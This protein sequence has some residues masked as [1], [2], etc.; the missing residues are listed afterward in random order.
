L[1]THS[2][3]GLGDLSR[4]L[5]MALCNRRGGQS[6]VRMIHIALP[7]RQHGVNDVVVILGQMFVEGVE[8]P[9]VPPAPRAGTGGKGN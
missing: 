4:V 3:R 7:H 1:I 2:R 6:R 5:A 9:R 8:E